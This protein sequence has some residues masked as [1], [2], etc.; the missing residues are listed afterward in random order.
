MEININIIFCDE[1]A[2]D[3]LAG[4]R[5][6]VALSL[7]WSDSCLSTAQKFFK[8]LIVIKRATILL[9]I[10]YL[11]FFNKEIHEYIITYE[12]AAKAIW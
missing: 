6:I 4:N 12:V 1:L 5:L 7:L 9:D 10:F 8:V 2:C 11:Q 3:E